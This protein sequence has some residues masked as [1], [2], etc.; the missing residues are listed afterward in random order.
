VAKVSASFTSGDEGVQWIKNE[1]FD[2]TDGHLGLSPVTGTPVPKVKG[3][4]TVKR[5]LL[6]SKVPG[7]VK[8][9]LPSNALFLIEEAWNAYPWCLT[10]LV[11]GYLDHKK[12]RIVSGAAASQVGEACRWVCSL[13]DCRAA[14][15]LRM[16]A[17]AAV[18]HLEPSPPPLRRRRR[19][20]L[21]RRCTWTR[22]STYPTRSR[23]RRRS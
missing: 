14:S 5:Y 23:S 15:T 3:Q 12:M 19:R 8:H 1:P 20:R 6:A 13:G 9:L 16:R 22:R 21:W 17:A 7:V 2:N 4:Y 18:A 10:V 11:N